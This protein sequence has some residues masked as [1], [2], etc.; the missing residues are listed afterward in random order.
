MG[1]KQKPGLLSDLSSSD[2]NKN[3]MLSMEID[4]FSFILDLSENYVNIVDVIIY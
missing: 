2:V 1:P 3:D 4:G